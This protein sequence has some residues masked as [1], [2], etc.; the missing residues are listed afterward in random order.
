MFNTFRGL[1]MF[2]LLSE[3]AKEKQQSW[4]V[5][6]EYRYSDAYFD[7]PQH[8]NRF[9]LFTKY[10]GKLS[11][12]ITSPFLPQHS[13]VNGMHRAKYPTVQL[14]KALLVFMERLILLKVALPIVQM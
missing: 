1:G 12:Q 6:S 5:A 8:F 10:N 4:Y 7:N 9:N 13:G 11:E 2:N 14:K 3:K